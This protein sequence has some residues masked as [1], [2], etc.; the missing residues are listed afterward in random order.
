MKSAVLLALIACLTSAL[1]V[2]AQ[3]AIDPGPIHRSIELEVSRLVS[4]QQ[5]LEIDPR[6]RGAIA[7]EQG[8]HVTI[9][10]RRGTRWSA[11]STGGRNCFAPPYGVGRYVVS[12]IG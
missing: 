6:W 7:L 12:Q 8:R 9:I 1:G 11:S 3:P 4:A 2:S 10:S 5:R